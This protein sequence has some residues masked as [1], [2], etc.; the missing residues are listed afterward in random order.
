MDGSFWGGGRI[1]PTTGGLSIF[2]IMAVFAILKPAIGFVLFLICL[3]IRFIDICV[4][5]FMYTY[6]YTYVCVYIYRE[7]DF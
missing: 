3:H 2:L 1:P 6:K 5:V 7:R 4:C